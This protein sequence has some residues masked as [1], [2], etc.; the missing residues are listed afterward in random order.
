MKQLDDSISQSEHKSPRSPST[1][2]LWLGLIPAMSVPFVASLFYFVWLSDHAA[3]PVIYT[4]AKIFILLWPLVCVFLL[5]KRGPVAFKEGWR[6]FNRHLRALPLGFFTGAAIATDRVTSCAMSALFG[7]L[8]GGKSCIR[9]G[10][11]H[12]NNGGYA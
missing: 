5:W 2:R 4:G 8:I 12:E 3:G 7:V 11:Q 9:N 1:R 6:P 10:N